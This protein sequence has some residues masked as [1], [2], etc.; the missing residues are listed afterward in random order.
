VTFSGARLRIVR[1]FQNLTQREL[2]E[3]IA[4]SHG[5]I[6]AF[7]NGTKEPKDD[8]LE[9]LCAA[10]FV[11]SHY[12]EGSQTDEFLE[13]ES[14][15]RKRVTATERLKRQVLA[16]ASLFAMAVRHLAN[17]G[18]FPTF[19]F[20]DLP[21]DSLDDVEG[22]AEHCQFH[23]ELENDAP[24]G[25]VARIAE[26]AGAV[27]LPIDIVTAEKVDAFSRFGDTSVIV[28]NLQKDSPSRFLFSLAHEIGHGVLHQKQRGLP[29]ERKEAEADAFASAFLLPRHA[30]AVDFQAHHHADWEGLLELKRYWRVSVQAIIR[31]AYDLRLI[32]AAEYRQRFRRL[33]GW[34]WRTNEPNEPEIDQPNLFRSALARARADFGKTELEIARD[35]GWTPQLFE[36]ATGIPLVPQIPNARVVGDITARRQISSTA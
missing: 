1:V 17:F 3:R 15:F 12:F 31:R 32:D 9:A 13:A 26:N 11:E 35:L 22:I 5:L 21:A 19:N 23:W 36:Q 2:A 20:P 24:I 18:E 4:V 6:A 34:G 33:S 7:E 27:I 28:L 14:N 8:I 29:L 10:L 30:F 25:D 16:R